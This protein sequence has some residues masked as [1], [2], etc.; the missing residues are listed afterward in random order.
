[1]VSPAGKHLGTIKVPEATSSLAFGDNDGRTPY[2]TATSSVYKLRVK[3]P[4]Q[5]VIYN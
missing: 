1:V 3:V 5:R 2:I 4:G